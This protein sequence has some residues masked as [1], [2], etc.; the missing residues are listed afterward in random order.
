MRTTCPGG[1][2]AGGLPP[3]WAGPPFPASGSPLERKA[4]RPAKLRKRCL[5]WDQSARSS[6]PSHP[7][8]RGNTLQSWLVSR[9]ISSALSRR[10][11]RP[12]P[13]PAHGE[14]GFK[15]VTQVLT[16]LPLRGRVSVC[17][18]TWELMAPSPA[19]CSRNAA[20]GLQGLVRKGR[21]SR[22]LSSG[23][24][25]LWEASSL[26]GVHTRPVL[27]R[28]PCQVL[29]SQPSWPPGGPNISCWPRPASPSEH[30]HMRPL[31]AESPRRTL[32]EFLPQ[33]IKGKSEWWWFYTIQPWVS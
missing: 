26:T 28:R 9:R 19:E 24:L 2:A 18:G 27:Q 33:K 15:K 13:V 14:G 1:G 22:P 30:N 21:A 31:L 16:L 17:P 6:H 5:P 20:P 32:P 11:R 8:G 7:R 3:P 25:A 4:G 29:R 23:T 10:A 12:S